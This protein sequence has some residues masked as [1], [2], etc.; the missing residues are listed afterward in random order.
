MIVYFLYCIITI[1]ILN[2]PQKSVLILNACKLVEKV[3]H[4]FIVDENV[5]WSDH[6][7]DSLAVP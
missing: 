3:W 5:N 6:F 2:Y 1:T 7:G 4:T